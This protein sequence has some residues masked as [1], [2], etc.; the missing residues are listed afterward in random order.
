MP[1]LPPLVVSLI[2]SFIYPSESQLKYWK[3]KHQCEFRTKVCH[4]FLPSR[5]IRA[6]RNYYFMG[7]FVH[8]REHLTL[9][10]YSDIREWFKQPVTWNLARGFS[11]PGRISLESVRNHIRRSL[12]Y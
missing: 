1:F 8:L 12:R 11:R 9:E 6:A 2:R 5:W 4:G 3:H 7:P 10:A